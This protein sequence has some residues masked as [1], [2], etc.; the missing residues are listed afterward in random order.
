MARDRFSE[1]DGF[2]LSPQMKFE[3]DALRDE[4]DDKPLMVIEHADYGM[5]DG[6]AV[7]E[8]MAV[9]LSE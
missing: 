9:L 3:E 4:L 5:M 1:F 2:L 7:V 6:E 8:K